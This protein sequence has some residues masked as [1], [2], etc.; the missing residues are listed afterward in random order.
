[1]AKR[2]M[3][4]KQRKIRDSATR[5]PTPRQRELLD[6]LMAERVVT[7]PDKDR[8]RNFLLPYVTNKGVNRTITYLQ[9]LP[10]KDSQPVRSS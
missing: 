5:W 4:D 8:I 3:A 1:M 9:K 7:D 2:S 6:S 10:L